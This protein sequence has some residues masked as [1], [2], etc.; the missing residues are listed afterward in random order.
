MLLFATFSFA[1]TRIEI[2]ELGES[3]LDK[4]FR[5]PNETREKHVRRLAVFRDTFLERAGHA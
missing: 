2:P 1:I 4:P 3:C 5:K